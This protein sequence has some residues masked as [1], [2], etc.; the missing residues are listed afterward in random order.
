MPPYLQSFSALIPRRFPW[1][2][3]PGLLECS[4]IIVNPLEKKRKVLEQ[5]HGG[6]LT[7]LVEVMDNYFIVPSVT[8]VSWGKM[9]ISSLAPQE[10]FLPLLNYWQLKVA[11]RRQLMFLEKKCN[12]STVSSSNTTCYY[13]SLQSK[14]YCW[15][16]LSS[17]KTGLKR[18]SSKKGNLY[19]SS[20]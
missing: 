3:V 14:W 10:G 11:Q 9:L 20:G 8:A 5:K 19:R 13:H 16:L 7:Y 4:T 6:H 2:I 12:F 17:G 15:N 1:L 18:P